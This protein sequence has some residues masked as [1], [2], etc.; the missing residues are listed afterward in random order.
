[1][2]R[3]LADSTKLLPQTRQEVFRAPDTSFSRSP[4]NIRSPVAGQLGAGAALPGIPHPSPVETL[5]VCWLTTKP[6]Q[7][8]WAPAPRRLD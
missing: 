1:M 7:T 2:W 3:P 8:L 5:Q 4:N 6:Q